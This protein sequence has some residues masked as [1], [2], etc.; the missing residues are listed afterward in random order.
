MTAARENGDG[1]CRPRRSNGDN[2]SGANGQGWTSTSRRS[3]LRGYVSD[4]AQDRESPWRDNP[5]RDRGSRQ[6]L[7]PWLRPKTPPA[8][9]APAPPRPKPPPPPPRLPP[10]PP[11]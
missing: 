1:A 5:M 10:K 9:P 11:A 7:E 8:P 3:D 6:H 4:Q 2:R